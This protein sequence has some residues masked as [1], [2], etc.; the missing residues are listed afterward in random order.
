MSGLSN[1]AAIVGIGE[2]DYS[3]KSGRSELRLATEA[4]LAALADAGVSPTEVDGL[5]TFSSDNNAEYEV[6]RSI[7]GRNLKYWARAHPGGGASCAPLQIAAMAVATGAAEIMVCYRAMNS[8]SQYRYGQ[9]YGGAHWGEPHPTADAVIKTMHTVHGLRTAAAMLAI[10]MRRYMHDFCVTGEDFAQVAVALRRHA[11]TNPRAFY[12]GRPITIE[13]HQKSRMIADPFRLLDCCQESDG[14]TAFVVTSVERARALPKPAAR[15]LAAAQG[16]CE[17]QVPMVNYYHSDISSFPESRLVAQQL[18]SDSGLVPE[19]VQLALIYDHF[20]PTVMPQL[21]AYGFCE[22]G[23]AKY[24]V[25]DGNIE[26]GGR[27]P[28]NP[29]GGQIGE[30]YMHG[31]NA[32]TEAVRQIRGIAANQVSNVEHILLTGAPGTT[33]SGALLGRL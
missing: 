29:H 22:R 26:L 16:S 13:D 10:P 30:A 17:R 32:V 19:N 15:I 33:T 20:S 2:T 25:R 9:G 3:K 18:Y 6:F 4:V 11:A 14:G 31:M 27:L 5:C 24:F 8:Y 23:Q 21:E 7:G 12:F 1:R 28:V